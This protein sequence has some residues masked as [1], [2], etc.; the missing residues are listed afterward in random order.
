M[1]R[2]DQ[3]SVRRDDRVPRS[4]RVELQRR[5]RPRFRA[6]HRAGRRRQCHLHKRR[7]RRRVPVGRQRADMESADRQA[8]DAIGR[9]S[10]SGAGRGAVAG[11]R[12]VQYRGQLVCRIGCLSPGES[13]E[14]ARSRSAIASAA[15]SSRARSSAR[16]GSTASATSTPRPRAACGGTQRRQRRAR[17]RRVLY[18]V[19][20]PVVNGVPRPDLQ[21]PYR[22]SATTSR[23]SQRQHGQSVLVNCAWRDGATYN[24]FYYS[25]DGGETF[26]RINPVVASTRRTSGAPRSRTRRRLTRSTRSSSR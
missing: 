8:A 11:H 2:G 14:P 4:V 1:G 21:S 6:P 23:S 13:G 25:T 16:S 10:T 15:P 12:R 26:A 3:P 17:W 20:D 19:P 22:T 7:Q 18:P 5:R 24:G 9:R